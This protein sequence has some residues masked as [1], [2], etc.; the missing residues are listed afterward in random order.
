MDRRCH[1]FVI[2]CTIVPTSDVLHWCFPN[3]TAVVSAITILR[4]ARSDRSV[5]SPTFVALLELAPGPGRA[6]LVIWAADRAVDHEAITWS[7]QRP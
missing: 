6:K 1:G 4:G 2:L 3:C 5:I 7:G